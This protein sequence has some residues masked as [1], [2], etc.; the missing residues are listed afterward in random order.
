MKLFIIILIILFIYILIYAFFTNKYVKYHKKANEESSMC[1]NL[2]TKMCKKKEDDVM[3][4]Q[5]LNQEYSASDVAKYVIK[6]C[7]KYNHPISN[8]QLQKILYF[9]WID[10]YREKQKALFEDRIFAWKLGPVVGSVYDEYKQ[11]GGG[12]IPFQGDG[13]KIDSIDELI[14]EPYILDYCKMSAF[15]LVEKSHCFGGAW[16]EIY[17]NGSG[18][19][20]II[21]FSLIRER[22]R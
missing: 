19:G 14:L 3:K 5:K 9:L 4:M 21:P 17:N 6:E 11:Y 10:Y 1:Y 20:Y 13:D 12:K 15:D 16:R 7:N 18:E 2:S 22:G 8:L